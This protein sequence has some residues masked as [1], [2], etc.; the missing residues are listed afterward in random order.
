MQTWQKIWLP[1]YLLTSTGRARQELGRKGPHRS[2][3]EGNYI[4][5]HARWFR[6]DGPHERKLLFILVC[7]GLCGPLRSRRWSRYGQIRILRLYQAPL[8]IQ[9][10]RIVQVGLKPAPTSQSGGAGVPRGCIALIR[11]FP[12]PP[13]LL[14]LLVLL[15]ILVLLAITTLL[16]EAR[17]AGEHGR[18]FLGA[19]VLEGRGEAQRTHRKL[20]S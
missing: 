19:W 4:T 2:A 5:I 10:I 15:V 1:P 14:F 17:A 20:Q 18:W 11:G 7:V 6:L 9:W 16:C 13:L 3:A 8:Q 12:R